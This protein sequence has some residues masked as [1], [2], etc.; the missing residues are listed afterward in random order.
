MSTQAGLMTVEEFLKLPPAKEGHY[1]LHRGEVILV[2]PAKRGLQRGQARIHNAL[3]RLA[4]EKGEVGTEYAFQPTP[5]YNVWEADVAFVRA[6][7]EKAVGDDEY[8][9]GAPDLVVEV[10]SPSNTADEMNDRM[11]ICL[12][13][14]CLSFW[15]VDQKRKRLSVTEGNVTRHYGISDSFHCG[16]LDAT[17]Q[18]REIFE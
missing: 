8:L 11:A 2:P 4:G 6:E 10:L 7:R 14:G 3:F 12:E 9:L 1:E 15:V 18:V 5:D 17:I 13:N 16:V